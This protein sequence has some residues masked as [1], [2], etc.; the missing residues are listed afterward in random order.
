MAA[1]VEKNC[2]PCMFRSLSAPRKVVM[3]F[4]NLQ[5]QNMLESL[6][7]PTCLG[8]LTEKREGVAEERTLRIFLSEL[9][10]PDPGPG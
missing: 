3:C 1:K 2:C 5:T 7:H 10:P 4:G 9:L 6:H 8:V